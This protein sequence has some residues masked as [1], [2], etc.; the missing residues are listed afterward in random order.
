NQGFNVQVISRLIEEDQVAALFQRQREVQ[1]VALTTGEY[2]RWL[3]LVWSLEAESRQVGARWHLILADVDVVQAFRAN[4]PHCCFGLDVRT[5]LL[6][7]R[8]LDGVANLH[9]SG[10][11]IFQAHD[12][13]KQGGLTNTVR[14]NNADDAVTRQ[15]KGQILNQDT[16]I[17]AL[18]QVLGFNNLVTQAWWSRNLDFFEVQLLVLLSLSRHFFVAFQTSLV[19]C[20]T[21]LRTGANPCQFVL[22]TLTQLG[23]L[24]ACY[25]QTF[26]LLLQVGG[27]V[28]FVW[29]Q[30]AAVN[31]TD[32]T[33]YVVKE[34]AVV[35]NGQNSAWVVFQVLFQPLH[36]LSIQVVSR[37]IEQQQVWLA[38][39][40]FRQSNAA[41]L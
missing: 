17:K 29:V 5:V 31:L 16:I 12:G 35:C 26:G 33:R 37:L 34:V 7:I 4:F 39:Q 27:V 24:L 19:L 21:C 25:F 9:G 15:G 23:I 32:P 38:Q 3:L 20:L 28:A 13:L 6:H 8:Q 2:L 1:A 14:A 41:A 18:A 40:Q 30:L 22:Q 36:G 10:I 11:W